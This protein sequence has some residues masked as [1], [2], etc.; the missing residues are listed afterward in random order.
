MYLKNLSSTLCVGF[1]SKSLLQW[2]VNSNFTTRSHFSYNSKDSTSESSS[3]TGE[4]NEHK[5]SFGSSKEQFDSQRSEYYRH[6]FHSSGEASG[7]GGNEKLHKGPNTTFTGQEKKSLASRWENAFFS[8]VH[9]EEGMHQ[10]YADA[11][12]AEQMESE[13]EKK[14]RF[15][16]GENSTMSKGTNATNP[17]GSAWFPHWCED[18][19]TP[20][21]LFHYLSA[22]EKLSF[23]VE[24][25]LKGERRIQFSPDYGGL[26]M[27][28][29]L[30]LGEFMLKDGEN[31]LLELEW[32]TPEV[33]SKIDQLKEL[34]ARIKFDYDLD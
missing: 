27:M 14:Q 18:E 34:A 8:R 32:M 25:L 22:K 20:R 21:N 17:R 31:L 16:D 5:N 11:V 30:N 26:S 33:Q 6:S 3:R 23:I 4:P 29:Q 19:L 10:R 24:R 1:W 7:L 28:A 13:D 2:Q 12:K 9:F 15:E